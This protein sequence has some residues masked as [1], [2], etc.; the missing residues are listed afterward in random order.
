MVRGELLL[1][2]DVSVAGN[3][4][5]GFKGRIAEVLVSLRAV[6]VIMFGELATSVAG[7]VGTSGEGL[8]M[9]GVDSIVSWRLV[10]VIV[11]PVAV[12]GKLVNSLDVSI[13]GDSA[14]GLTLKALE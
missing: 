1:S 5:E 12:S 8:K 2:R 7:S 6:P 14:E 10:S 13:V 9:G 4:V 11:F 3:S